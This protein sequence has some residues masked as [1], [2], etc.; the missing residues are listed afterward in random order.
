MPC[1]PLNWG[2]FPTW[3]SAV[4]SV[5]ALIFAALAAIAAY[6]LFKVETERDSRQGDEERRAR[7]AHA[8][9]AWYAL[10]AERR[11]Y[12]C[13]LR[14]ASD[15]P[16]YDVA[17]EYYLPIP[18]E[19]LSFWGVGDHAVLPPSERPQFIPLSHHLGAEI[20]AVAEAVVALSFP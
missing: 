8:V 17:I 16:V 15:S 1:G 5:G 19:G 4:A 2:D 20:G 11:L 10:D 3:I 6:R 13:H 9:S 12:G 18:G 14:N 7:Q